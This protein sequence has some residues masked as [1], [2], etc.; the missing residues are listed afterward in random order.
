MT[1]RLVCIALL[2]LLA[3]C[4]T[5]GPG[6]KPPAPGVKVGK[7]YSINGDTYYPEY[8]PH[9]DRTGLASW[10]GPGFHGKSTAN[11]EKF[12][13][14]DLT[15]AHP[16]LPMPSLVRVT[17]LENG[18]S[19]VIRINDRG[20]FKN[21]RLIDLSKASAEALGVTGLAK[22]RVQYLKEETEQYWAQMNLGT[23][24]ISF[25]K[26]DKYAPKGGL[27]GMTLPQDNMPSQVADAAP[28]LSVASNDLEPPPP[29]KELAKLHDDIESGRSPKVVQLMDANG[30]PIRSPGAPGGPKV[31]KVI[32]APTPPQAPQPSAPRLVSGGATPEGRWFIQAGAFSSEDNAQRLAERLKTYA[33]TDILPLETGGRTLHRVRVGPFENQASAAEALSRLQEQGVSDA[34]ISR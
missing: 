9:Y 26:N 14:H 2:A 24:D 25:A 6:P 34:R 3:A 4:G 33:G 19:E 21:K 15:A 23:K 16:T 12:D 20:P 22:V 1:K 10:Y 28:V 31:V 8:D 7:P 11:G 29:A 18:Q 30:N 13:Q 27:D 32:A 17:N 5:K